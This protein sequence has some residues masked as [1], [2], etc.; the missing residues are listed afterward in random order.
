MVKEV[1]SAST[2]RQKLKV[3]IEVV[4]SPIILNFIKEKLTV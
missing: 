1:T 2:V 4:T 3:R